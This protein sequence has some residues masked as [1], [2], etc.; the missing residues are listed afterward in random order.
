MNEESA[1]R[2]DTIPMHRGESDPTPAIAPSPA[3]PEPTEEF[4]K[5]YQR[6][7]RWKGPHG[8]REAQAKVREFWL[9]QGVSGMRWI[10]RR[11]RQEGHLD[12]LHGASS[13]LSDA[14]T[15]AI[16]PILEELE[17]QP[18]MDQ[19]DTLLNALALLGEDGVE[20]PR[21]LV[22]LLEAALAGFLD[23]READLRESAAVA[24]RLL[25]ADRSAYWLRR[26]RPLETDPDVSAT[27]ANELLKK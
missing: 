4:E 17:R 5:Q 3:G 24:M 16:P 26:R 8:T 15:D 14:G 9:S 20:A 7:G 25:P 22:A 13:L 2:L 11:L 10:A 1:H 21:S 27:L 6:I 12:A 19:A 18:S 23:H